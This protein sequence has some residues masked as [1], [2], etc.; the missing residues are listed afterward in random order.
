M[1]NTWWVNPFQMYQQGPKA[2]RAPAPPPRRQTNKAVFDPFAQPDVRIRP[3]SPSAPTTSL[4]PLPG[5]DMLAQPSQPSLALPNQGA[6]LL[7]SLMDAQRPVTLPEGL[8]PQSLLGQLQKERFLSRLWPSFIDFQEYEKTKDEAGMSPRDL[9]AKYREQVAANTVGP[10]ALELA[11]LEGDVEAGTKRLEAIEALRG[12]PL[13]KP[14]E[15]TPTPLPE[16]E[17]IPIPKRGRPKLDKAGLAVSAIAG[18][19]NPQVGLSVFGGLSKAAMD[20]VETELA[21][22]RIEYQAALDAAER[23]YQTALQ[24]R[25]EAEQARMTNMQARNQWRLQDWTARS[26]LTKSEADI[27]ANIAKASAA[28]GAL[29]T[30][31]ERERK[32]MEAG[33]KLAHLENIVAAERALAIARQNYETEAAKARNTASIAAMNAY[34]QLIEAALRA[35]T[36]GGGQ[37]I[38]GLDMFKTLME[39]QKFDLDYRKTLLEQVRQSPGYIKLSQDMDMTAKQ[40][41]ERFNQLFA[42]MKIVNVSP[43]SVLNVVTSPEWALAIREDERLRQL[44]KQLKDYARQNQAYQEFFK[45]M[46]K[47]TFGVNLPGWDAAPSVGEMTFDFGQGRLVP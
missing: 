21:D 30:L 34:T 1:Q 7:R 13:P 32:A 41:A 10:V 38:A 15:F 46:Y 43:E 24:Q 42:G 2:R 36:S 23:R 29:G 17:E 8:D 26:E 3:M 22:A 12:M 39:L 31:A 18:L 11:K 28:K 14:E 25:A 16:R 40:F 35:Y 4:P 6:D 33:S 9:I 45:Q 44:A 37:G 5:T 20:K 19:I 27:A 47:A